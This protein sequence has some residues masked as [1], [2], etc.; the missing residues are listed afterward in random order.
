MDPRGIVPTVRDPPALGSIE[1]SE[2][3]AAINHGNANCP[4]GIRARADRT[5]ARAILL[6]EPKGRQETP[7]RPS[8]LRKKIRRQHPLDLGWRSVRTPSRDDAQ[9]KPERERPTCSAPGRR[10]MIVKFPYSASRRVYSRRG[11][12]SKNGTPEERAA[13]AAATAAE[14]TSAAVTEI[15][16][17]SGDLHRGIG[18]GMYTRK[19]YATREASW[20]GPG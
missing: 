1:P 2:G 13:K 8:R 3:G 17:R 6:R 15:S 4:R 16:S 9:A 19:A 11:R 12:V 7:L 5:P 10:G 20:R 14:L 18:G